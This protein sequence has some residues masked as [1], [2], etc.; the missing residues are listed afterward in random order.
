MSL[1]ELYRYLRWRMDPE[2]ERAVERFRRIVKFFE[3]LPDLPGGGR[4]LDIC[5]GTGIAGAAV[6]KATG[7][8]LLT[9]LDARRED[10]E[11]V[12][13]W[14]DIA[15]IGPDVR[16]VIGDA[17]NVAE[18]VG[19]HDIAVLWGLTMP[20]FDPFD[21]VKLFAGVASILSDNGVFL[22]EETDRVYGILYRIGY[23]D[24][25]IEAKG[26]DYTLISLHEGYNI[27]RGM[28][29]RTYY[30]LPGFDKV[31]E[32][33]FRLWDIASQLAIGSVF[34]REWRLIGRE[35]HGVV[36]VSDVLYFR[37]PRKDVAKAV[38][39]DK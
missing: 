11:K 29:R 21:A 26:G 17:R 16:K 35:E 27:M 2:D 25:L 37:G 1:E 15:E 30:K 32:Q 19:K 20:H 23:K 7:A 34:F 5:A 22:I 13:A 36:G 24:M 14:V 3:S 31:A 10:L 6:A 28:F 12:S 9:V 39:G 4:V 38:L 8:K 33:E 18:L